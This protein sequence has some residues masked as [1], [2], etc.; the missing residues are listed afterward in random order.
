[1]PK[2]LF[3]IN[4]FS[5][6][7]ISDPID[8]F[9]IPNGAASVSLNIDPLNEGELKGIPDVQVLKDT[10]FQ[11]NFTAVAYVRPSSYSSTEEVITAYNHEEQHSTE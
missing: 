4:A 1:M 11:N 7:I 8:E 10:G 9:D 3:E 5:S 2:Q 6:G